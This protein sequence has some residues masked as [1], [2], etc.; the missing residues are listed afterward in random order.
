MKLKRISGC[1]LAGIMSMVLFA[2]GFS[3]SAL[4]AESLFEDS[5]YDGETMTDE[6]SV[7]SSEK[8]DDTETVPENTESEADDALYGTGYQLKYES[9]KDENGQNYAVVTGMTG[10]PSGSLVIP[11][12]DPS[13]GYSV[14]EIG[15]NAFL[16]R[17]G[18]NGTL[19]LPDTLR[20]IGKH[21]FG[22]CS[23]LTGTLTIPDGVTVIGDDAFVRCSGFTGDLTIPDSVQKV[24]GYAFYE[25][26]GLT[27]NLLLGKNVTEIGNWAFR[28]CAFTGGLELP[29]GLV[30]I[31]SIAFYNMIGLTGSLELPAGLQTIGASAFYGCTG[32]TGGLVIPD[33]VI[34]IDTSAFGGCTGFDG[35]LT[36]GRSLETIGNASFNG[37][38]G[39]TGDLVIPDSVTSIGVSAFYEC[40]G[41]SGKLIIGDGV[42]TI[43]YGAFSG[44]KNMAGTLTIGS[45][46]KTIEGNAFSECGFTETLV[47]PDSVTSIGMSAF[48]KCNG[49]TGDL[50]I[51]DSVTEFNGG[52]EDCTGF[53]GKLKL[54]A[55]ITKIPTGAF[56]GCK[57]LTGELVIPE[58]VTEIGVDAFLGCEKLTG[59]LV[60]PAGLS[61][62]GQRA[63]KGCKG[64][65][66]T[67]N[68]P[69][70]LRVISDYSFADM[71]GL[72]GDIIISS[73]VATIGRS[74]FYIKCTSALY[75][76]YEPL[77]QSIYFPDTL[78]EIADNAFDYYYSNGRSSKDMNNGVTYLCGTGG[79]PHTWVMNKCPDKFQEWDG[80]MEYH[81]T[82]DPNGGAGDV[83]AAATYDMGTDITLPGEGN[84]Q[85]VGY[86]FLGWSTRKVPIVTDTIY[87]PGD[88]YPS[89]ARN[90]TFYAFWKK[91][92]A[93]YTVTYD[94]NG[95]EGVAPADNTKYLEGSDV[96]VL[97]AGTLHKE[98]YVF[99]GWSTKLDPYPLEVCLKG[100]TLKNIQKNTTLYAIWE[101]PVELPLNEYHDVTQD[102]IASG[103]TSVYQFTIS[104]QDT[105]KDGK[106]MLNMVVELKGECSTIRFRFTIYDSDGGIIPLTDDG[107][108][109]VPNPFHDRLNGASAY[110]GF[111]LVYRRIML[112]AGTYYIDVRQE[113]SIRMGSMPEK[114]YIY[115]IFYPYGIYLTPYR[116][117]FDLVEDSIPV[118]NCDQYFVM[119]P[120]YFTKNS[121]KNTYYRG[122]PIIKPQSAGHC[123]GLSLAC[124]M[125]YSDDILMQ[126]PEDYTFPNLNTKG[127]DKRD[128]NSM[129]IYTESTGLGEFIN[130]LC[131]MQ[132]SYEWHAWKKAYDLNLNATG[133]LIGILNDSS[134]PILLIVKWNDGGHAIVADTSRKPL[135]LGNGWYRV[136]IYDNNYP[137]DRILSYDDN[138]ALIALGIEGQKADESYKRSLDS[139]IDINVDTNAWDS[140]FGLTTGSLSQLRGEGNP[141]VAGEAKASAKIY[142]FGSKE[143]LLAYPWVM[144]SEFLK[145]KV[146]YSG[147]VDGINDGLVDELMDA[148]LDVNDSV[149]SI[150]DG[151]LCVLSGED[152][153]YE[154]KNGET[155]YCDESIEEDFIIGYSPYDTDAPNMS[156][157]YMPV[158]DYEFILDGASI[159]YGT[160][161]GLITLETDDVIHFKASSPSSAV[162]WS[163][164]QGASVIVNVTE[165]EEDDENAFCNVG[166]EL[167]L[168]TDET[169]VSLIGNN[170]SVDT[171]VAQNIDLAIQTESDE[172]TLENVSTDNLKNVDLNEVKDGV[173]MKGF[174]DTGY[175]YTGSAIRPEIS[176]F[177]GVKSLKEKTD[178]TISYKNNKKAYTLSPEDKGF[179]AKKA[180][181]VTV[182]GKGNYTNKETIYFK[183][184]PKD[185]SGE[186]F[187]ADDMAF[188]TP[189]KK[190]KVSPVLYLN[191]KALKNG[192]DYKTEVFR[193]DDAGRSTP[194]GSYVKDPG[195]YV[196]RL[197]GK[198]NYTGTR[199]INLKVSR[200]L[201]PV[202]ALR[203]GTIPDC[204]YNGNP[205]YPE[206][207]VSDG[208]TVLEKG[209]HYTLS[210]PLPNTEIGNGYL[211]VKGNP[212][213]GYCGTRRISFKIIGTSLKNASVQ[214]PKNSVY[215][216]NAMDLDADNLKLTIKDGDMEKVLTR[217]VDYKV[218]YL[219]NTAIGKATVILD[220]IGGYTGRI[221]KTVK[222]LPFNIDPASDTTGRVHMDYED[223]VTYAKGG[224]VPQIR[225]SFEATDGTVK[226]LVNGK[227]YKITCRYNTSAGG[228]KS[229]A[230]TVTGKGIFSGSRSFTYA[231]TQQDLSAVEL[232]VTDR[233]YKNKAGSYAS[234]VTLTDRNG[235]KLKAGTD[236]EKKV[237]YTYENTTTV[238]VNGNP[239]ER[240]AG[241][242]VGNKDIVPAGTVIRVTVKAKDGSNYTG[243]LTGAYRIVGCLISSAKV[244]GITS[245][246]YT[247]KKITFDPADITV[248][249]NGKKLVPYDSETGEG[250]FEISYINNTR[251]GTATA[252][253][254]GKNNYG[255]TRTVKFRIK[256]RGFRWWWR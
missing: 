214:I 1:V 189:K 48:S 155:V 30:S 188:S 197:T 51:P 53:G 205:F 183:I 112:P 63:F 215:S 184:L 237:V 49:F 233:A 163:E 229:P 152:K 252:I 89:I 32:F 226:E 176:V 94:A 193:A 220:G 46:V 113:N 73:G 37:C 55:N 156:R 82:Y 126:L 132:W 170:L 21:A 247:G 128:D 62:I 186:E 221:R 115:G 61:A 34:S 158:G 79:Y 239:V 208:S 204:R 15:E 232:K 28:G 236:Y 209:I 179:K 213:A 24:G 110:R 254:T 100:D 42:E 13:T 107:G 173:W 120:P 218:S 165:Y 138:A 143:G 17:G 90:V 253:I 10:T 101:V 5:L 31:G 198:N 26:S 190:Q 234:T 166:T 147:Y 3:S 131:L 43:G 54:P 185:I 210:Y 172:K 162:L 33:S 244:T 68:I 36:L 181:S 200:E 130:E 187:D 243:V 157:L 231:I 256:A 40:T 14:R 18:F 175:A 72:N 57:N 135:S 249:V 141:R 228:T 99:R 50:I 127:F 27:G 111:N 12:K 195:D 251:K 250:D 9:Q 216:G 123:L 66:G 118:M 119:D 136:F 242:T 81:V 212:D 178:Y 85:K 29:D 60:L 164:E 191:G 65:T 93:K 133:D 194:L 201:K 67:L 104:D 2:D 149:A 87:E 108:K 106:A 78:T 97:G 114:D 144:T 161:D 11:D 86:D 84:L 240:A 7:D 182:T 150:F 159:D 199:E 122:A 70:T 22:G 235:K 83:P 177:D 196:V 116:E 168:S 255:G 246:I 124:I 248:K 47:I 88:T 245:Q 129:A 192:T 223:A 139:Y 224:A 8:E 121:M 91:Q 102:D 211:L 109:E 203:I 167:V 19:T 76:T 117:G 98:G 145:G 146:R 217:D 16:D 103:R 95:A 169:T 134:D 241:E 125:Q 64:F 151:D 105:F 69:G 171:P 96:T 25:C 174:A 44:C 225:L 35:T 140:Y 41:F 58:T 52:F 238:A 20:K 75:S 227:D 59:E 202:S 56:S 77:I 38:S 154:R 153:V 80:K 6:I 206:P 148:F 45:S 230:C 160:G 71:E 39:F 74:A 207:T 92:P 137:H 180:P 4:A 23:G 219:H 222:I 142:A